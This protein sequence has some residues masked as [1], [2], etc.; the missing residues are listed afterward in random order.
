MDELAINGLD[1][2]PSESDKIL[3]SPAVFC[4]TAIPAAA[5]QAAGDIGV[6]TIVAGLLTAAGLFKQSD[7]LEKQGYLFEAQRDVVLRNVA[8]SERTYNDTFLPSYKQGVN[9][10]EKGFRKQWE[11]ILTKI[12]TC[13]TQEC[14]YVPDYERHTTRGLADA[15]KIISGVKRTARRALD[16]YS[17]GL[18]SEQSFKFAEVQARMVIDSKVLG[19]TFE[20][21]LKLR[22]DTFYWNRLTTSASIA[23]NVGSLSANLL[24]QGKASLINGLQAINQAASGFDNAV[25]SG[26]SVLSREGSFYGGLG[27]AANGLF[28]QRDSA[29]DANRVANQGDFGPLPSPFEADL[30]ERA[31]SPDAIYKPSGLDINPARMTTANNSGEVVTNQGFSATPSVEQFVNGLE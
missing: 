12:V 24:I 31:F 2:T 8:L 18:C 14:E 29:A 13:G 16:A 15:A 10:F 19:R 25:A 27:A 23:Q 30:S 7:R 9:F 17:I 5:I 1:L 3:S 6:K 28:N 20:E 26:F 11:P 21:D 4:P 22:K